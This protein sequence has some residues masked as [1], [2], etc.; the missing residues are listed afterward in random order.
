VSF[1]GAAFD[2]YFLPF[3]NRHDC[4][5][6]ANKFE[7]TRTAS[8]MKFTLYFAAVPILTGLRF[9]QAQY[10]PNPCLANPWSRDLVGNRIP[11]QHLK[12]SVA[13]NLDQVSRALPFVKDKMSIP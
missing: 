10:L 13:L 8:A 6:F 7:V 3:L 5:T 2:E 11:S 12:T 1:F 4:S 9:A